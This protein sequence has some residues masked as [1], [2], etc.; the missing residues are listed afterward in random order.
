MIS[1]F[2]F[3]TVLSHSDFSLNCADLNLIKFDGTLLEIFFLSVNV[4]TR[5]DFGLSSQVRDFLWGGIYRVCI[6]V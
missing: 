1:F 5:G 4:Y 6:E 2:F 3:T